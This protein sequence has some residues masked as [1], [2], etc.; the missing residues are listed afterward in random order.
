MVWIN[1]VNLPLPEL[2]WCG[3]K[4][5]AIGINLSRNAVIEATNLKVVQ[6]DSDKENRVWWFP[7]KKITEG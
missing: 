7:Y 4:Q 1:E 6:Y 2:A 5:S 3:T